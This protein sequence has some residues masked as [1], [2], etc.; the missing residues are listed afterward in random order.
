MLKLTV[1]QG[2][3]LAQKMGTLVKVMTNGTLLQDEF[4]SD[5][6]WRQA[7]ND[8]SEHIAPAKAKSCEN[9]R[10]QCLTSQIIDF[11]INDPKDN[12][13]KHGFENN[14]PGY[15]CEFIII[16]I[17]F[18]GGQFIHWKWFLIKLYLDVVGG[19][20]LQKRWHPVVCE[21][22]WKRASFGK[23]SFCPHAGDQISKSNHH[24]TR[25]YTT[26]SFKPLPPLNSCDNKAKKELNYTI[27]PA[28]CQGLSTV[29]STYGIGSNVMDF[30]CC[31]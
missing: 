2:E 25:A 24:I 9:C 17:L 10:M 4:S 5:F 27:H 22:W 8:L 7:W 3:A 12:C 20:I 26:I 11:W 1:D 30:S 19:D 18:Y 21:L 14:E 13:I 15:I 6:L 23:R 31:N 29:C 28:W 16:V